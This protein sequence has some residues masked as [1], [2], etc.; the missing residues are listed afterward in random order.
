VVTRHATS[1]RFA[2]TLARLALLLPL[3]LPPG[4]ASAAD[5]AQSSSTPVANAPVYKPPARGKPRGRVGGGTRSAGPLAAAPLA[6]VPDHIGATLSAQPTLFYSLA[7][8]PPQGAKLVFALTDESSVEPLVESELARPAAPGIQAI[9]LAKYGVELRPEVEYEWTVTLVSDP[10]KRSA[11]L[12]TAG[13]IERVA[14][15][16]GLDASD[17]A[18]LAA[19]GFWYDAFAKAPEPLRQALLRD[20]GLAP[21]AA[22]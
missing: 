6:L 14:P 1:R 18:A 2:R 3:V 16:A 7:A 15:P 11:D 5:P 8:L 22:R 12:I 13:W 10:G 4:E 19:Q 9:E 20:A 21:A 17:P